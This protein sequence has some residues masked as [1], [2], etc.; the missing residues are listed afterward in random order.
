M[1]WHQ[2]LHPGWPV[3]TQIEKEI[4]KIGALPPGFRQCQGKQ[5]CKESELMGLL[6]HFTGRSLANSFRGRGS[7]AV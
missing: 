6:V 4:K 5:G 2:I 3:R 7:A 1:P